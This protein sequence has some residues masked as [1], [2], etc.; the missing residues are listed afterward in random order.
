MKFFDSLKNNAAKSRLTEEM[1]YEQVSEELKNGIRREGL[2]T[3][4]VAE[5][6]GN[7]DVAKSIYI[8]LRFQS[9]VDEVT[10]VSN[11]KSEQEKAS[12]HLHQNN[13]NSED[14]TVK[15]TSSSS[16]VTEKTLVCL[17]CNREGKMYIKPVPTTL[18]AKFYIGIFSLLGTILFAILI[19][20][21]ELAGILFLPIYSLCCYVIYVEFFR[22][23]CIQCPSC[24]NRS[25]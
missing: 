6:N 11:A 5:S 3:K 16:E 10:V 2:W 1:I 14:K 23:T 22:K 8:K 21:S 7:D 24:G 12:S 17:S 25:E 15:K 13:L 9:I 18:V 4:A 20:S 19:G